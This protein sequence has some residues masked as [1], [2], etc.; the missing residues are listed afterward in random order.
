MITMGTFNFEI[1]SQSYEIVV[2]KTHEL[3]SKND[4]ENGIYYLNKAIELSKELID[5][6]VIIELKNKYIS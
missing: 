5:N 2:K 4:L 3:L 6:C 1:K